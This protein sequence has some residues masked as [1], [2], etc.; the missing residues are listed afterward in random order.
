MGICDP[1]RD[2]R[3]GVDCELHGASDVPPSLST[4]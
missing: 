1:G 4:L 3:M 2:H